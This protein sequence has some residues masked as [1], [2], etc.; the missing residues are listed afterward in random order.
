MREEE[1][2]KALQEAIVAERLDILKLS[3]ATKE[4]QEMKEA[5]AEE[6]PKG[7]RDRDRGDKNRREREKGEKDGRNRSSGRKKNADESRS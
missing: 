1:V 2:E 7:R 5:V 4:G 6:K 3:L